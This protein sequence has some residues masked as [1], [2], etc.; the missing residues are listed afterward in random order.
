MNDIQDLKELLE[1]HLRFTNSTVA[2]DI[3]G[4]W[5]QSAHEV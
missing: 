4:R 1:A 2:K 5:P 3:L